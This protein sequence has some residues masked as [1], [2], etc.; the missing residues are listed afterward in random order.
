MAAYTPRPGIRTWLAASGAVGGGSGNLTAKPGL[1]V[2]A[3]SRD[4]NKLDIFVAGNDGKTYTAAWD[5]NVSSV[6]S[7]AWLVEHPDRR[8]PVGRH[9]FGRLAWSQ[10]AGYLSRKHGWRR[11]Y[12]RLGTGRGQQPVA[13]LVAHPAV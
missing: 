1:S 11:I 3:V 10:Q 8:H 4:P 2:A 6:L 7:V 12:C 9:D 5:Q 13:W